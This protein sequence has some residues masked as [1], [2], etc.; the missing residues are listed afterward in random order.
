MYLQIHHN[1]L[2]AKFEIFIEDVLLYQKSSVKNSWPQLSH[3]F[4]EI[5]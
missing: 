1:H 5:S 4:I 3:S 2:L